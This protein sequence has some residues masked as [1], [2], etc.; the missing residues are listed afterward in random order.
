MSSSQQKL[1]ATVRELEREL[2]AAHHL[3]AESRQLLSQAA[4][5]IHEVLQRHDGEKAAV[6]A[7][8]AAPVGSGSLVERM[9]DA[10]RRFEASHPLL[11][12]ILE[13]IA[14]SLGQMGI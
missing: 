11:S 13:Q 12:G 8:S 1:R 14:E 2:S 7:A 3:D 5:E 10:A 6:E 9:N 4:S